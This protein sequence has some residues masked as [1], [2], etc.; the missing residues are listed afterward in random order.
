MQK[1][2]PNLTVAAERPL[3]WPVPQKPSLGRL[4]LNALDALVRNFK[5]V[6]DGNTPAA[7]KRLQERREAICKACEFYQHG[8]CTKCGCFLKA[9]TW[10]NAEVCPVGKW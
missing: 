5:W 2:E 1:F 7:R 9:K 8:I 3:T 10:L 4:L 6:G